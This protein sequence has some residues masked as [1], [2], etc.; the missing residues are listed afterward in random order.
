MVQLTRASDR[1]PDLQ[2]DVRLRDCE[3]GATEDVSI[4]PAVRTRYQDAYDR[5]D[6][7]LQGFADRAGVGLLRLD[8]DAEVTEQ[9]ATLFESGR[10]LA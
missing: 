5:F 10:Y 7:G 4:T 8:A 6:A 9:L 3:T 2:G 1:D